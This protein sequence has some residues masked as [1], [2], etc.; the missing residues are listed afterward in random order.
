MKKLESVKDLTYILSE[1]NLGV[2]K[3]TLLKIYKAATHERPDFLL[4]DLQGDPS[5]RFRRNFLEIFE[6]PDTF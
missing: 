4:I 3:K 2:D 5:K 6:I 1:Y